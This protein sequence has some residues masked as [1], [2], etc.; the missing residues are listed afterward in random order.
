MTTSRV[1]RRYAEAIFQAAQRRR[2]VAEIGQELEA[3]AR[4]IASVAEARTLI[5]HPEIPLERRL[6]ILNRVFADQLEPETLALLRLLVERN[7]LDELDAIAD[8]YGLLADEAANIQRGQVRS[9][10]PLSEEELTRLRAALARRTGK[11]VILES[12]VDPSLLAGLWVRVGDYVLDASAEG[13]LQALR[14]TLMEM[15]G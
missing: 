3:L 6:A 5:G 14:E 9:A 10:V 4:T 7:R 13:R 12:H 2:A 11:T 1:A 15:R 8:I